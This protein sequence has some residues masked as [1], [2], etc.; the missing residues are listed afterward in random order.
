LLRSLKLISLL[1][2]AF[3]ALVDAQ[4]VRIHA[5]VAAQALSISLVN[6]STRSY[7][8]LIGGLFGPYPSPALHFSVEGLGQLDGEVYMASD[9]PGVIGGRADSWVIPIPSGGS[10]K[11]AIPLGRLY[12]RKQFHT[13]LN[14][15]AQKPWRLTVVYTARSDP[16]YYLL[17][18]RAVSAFPFW[19]GTLR[20]SVENIGAAH[21]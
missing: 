19:V 6:E 5:E 14:A 21:H 3:A 2:A 16:E 7:A 12:L 13:T 4:D 1:S 8:F 11:L 9:A 15:L 17:W 18:K 20:G 10:T